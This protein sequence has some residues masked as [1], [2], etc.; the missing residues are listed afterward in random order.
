M[1]GI[2]WFVLYTGAQKKL[3]QRNSSS[4]DF[5]FIVLLVIRLGKAHATGKLSTALS[6]ESPRQEP[7]LG[8]RIFLLAGD[9]FSNFMLSQCPLAGAMAKRLPFSIT[10][11]TILS[12]L[13][14]NSLLVF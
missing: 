7:G 14:P 2:S 1:D 13:L 5:L 3:R 12:S 8:V 4:Y 9:A 11:L 6:Q 10:V